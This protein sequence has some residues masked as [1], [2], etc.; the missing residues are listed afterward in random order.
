MHEYKLIFQFVDPNAPDFSDPDIM[1]A[2]SKAVEFYNESSKPHRSIIDVASFSEGAL[3][4]SLESKRPL[5]APTKSLKPFIDFLKDPDEGALAS[6]ISHG[7]L[8]TVVLEQDYEPEERSFKH[9]DEAIE[10]MY[11]NYTAEELDEELEARI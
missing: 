8:F 9:W 7:R 3:E 4:I 11:S 5:S 1:D 2:I 10:L 6:Y